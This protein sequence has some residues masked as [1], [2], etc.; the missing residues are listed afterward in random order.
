M[1]TLCEWT[2]GGSKKKS[3]SLYIALVRI[4]RDYW[5]KFFKECCKIG[6]GTKKAIKWFEDWK[7]VLVWNTERTQWVQFIK[8][9]KRTQL[10]FK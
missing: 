5:S 8:K 1:W 10:E 2:G 6:E 7:N 9:M 3:C 4:A